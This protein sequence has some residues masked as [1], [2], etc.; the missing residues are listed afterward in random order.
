M[1]QSG[2]S[3][4]DITPRFMLQSDVQHLPSLR[5]DF[6]FNDRNSSQVQFKLAND[7]SPRDIRKFMRQVSDDNRD[8]LKDT[9]KVDFK[10]STLPI[11]L[12]MSSAR[13][14]SLKKSAIADKSEVFSEINENEENFD[15]MRVSRLLERKE[16]SFSLLVKRTCDPQDSNCAEAIEQA[17]NPEELLEQDLDEANRHSRG[18]AG[19]TGVSLAPKRGFQITSNVQKNYEDRMKIQVTDQDDRRSPSLLASAPINS[20]RRSSLNS[21]RQIQFANTCGLIQPATNCGPSQ[22]HQTLLSSSFRFANMTCTPASVGPAVGTLFKFIKIGAQV[23]RI[24]CEIDKNV[25]KY[26]KMTFVLRAEDQ[27]IV[28]KRLVSLRDLDVIIGKRLFFRVLLPYFTRSNLKSVHNLVKCGLLHFVLAERFSPDAVLDQNGSLASKKGQSKGESRII[29]LDFINESALEEDQSP[30]LPFRIIMSD[31]PLSLLNDILI[32]LDGENYIVF[33][34]HLSG[35]VFRFIMVNISERQSVREMF[36]FDIRFSPADI[37]SFFDLQPNSD[38][39]KSR[40]MNF[41]L[42]GRQS[43]HRFAAESPFLKVDRR[44]TVRSERVQSLTEALV[45][46]VEKNFSKMK[47][48]S[49]KNESSAFFVAISELESNKYEVFSIAPSKESPHQFLITYRDTSAH[50]VT[51]GEIIRV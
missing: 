39:A 45:K 13:Q 31:F 26:K 30:N 9:G 1:T 7:Y 21:S 49:K 44:I 28:A 3:G 12:R 46:I 24:E 4:V 11:D 36:D 14:S 20:R 38:P 27:S 42:N 22:F 15:Q 10:A 41:R 34:L 37:N 19:P 35:F 25:S 47:I 51:A 40:R 8:I 50:I 6:S 17:L 16:K 2:L 18:M 23:F 32:R 29:G 48:F 43:T 5:Q 33:F